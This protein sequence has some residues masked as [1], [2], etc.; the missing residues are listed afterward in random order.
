MTASFIALAKSS[1]IHGKNHTL[2]VYRKYMLEGEVIL[3]RVLFDLL[4]AGGYILYAR[5]GEATVG[6]DMPNLNFQYCYTQRNLSELG[7]RQ[8]FYYGEA[9]RR[10]QIPISY[11]IVVSPFCRTIE[12]AQMAF[13]RPNVI[14]DPFW[15]EVY[16]L[17]GNLSNIEKQRI[18]SSLR[19]KLEIKP[20][21]GSNRVIIAHSFPEGI[22]LGQIP[23]MGTVI[24]R[25]LGQGRGYEIID[26]L[27]LE[28]LANLFR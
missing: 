27:T 24:I 10:Q 19:S 3:K 26:K 2:L 4:R 22:G 12:T 28:D 6:E 21:Q 20:P 5:H 15:A 11:P 7:R 13:G 8:A 14:A 16:R 9:L 1:T 23:N 17:G 25:P 18:L